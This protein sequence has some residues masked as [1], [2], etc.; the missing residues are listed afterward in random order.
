MALKRG[1]A[2]QYDIE[3]RQHRSELLHFHRRRDQ[4]RV[5]NGVVVL[6][7]VSPRQFGLRLTDVHFAARQ[8]AGAL[9]QIVVQY[10][11]KGDGLIGRLAGLGQLELSGLDCTLELQFVTGGRGVSV[12]GNQ[13]LE[14]GRTTHEA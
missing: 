1:P 13:S 6:Y 3:G 9:S 5:E 10:E 4:L 8:R 2:R 7:P 14:S 11:I 12:D